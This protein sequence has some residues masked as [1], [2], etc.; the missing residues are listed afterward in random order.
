MNK[1]IRGLLAGG[2]SLA[3]FVSLGCGGDKKEDDKKAPAAPA[4][5]TTTTT[6]PAKAPEVKAERPKDG[7]H[8]KYPPYINDVKKTPPMTPEMVKYVDDFYAQVKL[9]PEAK[10]K[11]YNDSKIFY[12]DEK[13]H[14]L[15]FHEEG[16][17]HNRTIKIKDSKGKERY[18]EEVF[19]IDM[20]T[21]AG[22]NK[23][24]HVEYRKFERNASNPDGKSTKI[25]E[26][27]FN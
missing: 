17:N 9:R 10:G 13:I 20:S 23:L 12:P 1:T 3:L 15:H 18:Q 21:Q 6:T 5:K 11:F 7:A 2:V 4:A 26:K 22:T 8:Y 14:R 24:L 25:M 19:H 16:A 27:K